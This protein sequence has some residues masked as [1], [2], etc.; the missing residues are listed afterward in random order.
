M[1]RKM[2]IAILAIFILAVTA[3]GIF[4][5]DIIYTTLFSPVSSYERIP[6]D[7]TKANSVTATPIEINQN[8]KY[9]HFRFSLEF[10]LEGVKDKNSPTNPVEKRER[11]AEFVGRSDKG[12]GVTIPVRL[13][14]KRME[15]GGQV[16]YHNKIY[17]TEGCRGWGS[18]S[19]TRQISV[20][21]MLPGHYLVQLENLE[22][23]ANVPVDIKVTLE[24]VQFGTK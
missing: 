24:V 3:G 22:E 1:F 13:T 17:Y 12:G 5:Y 19:F 21:H 15:K 16:T 9:D 23:I 6:I 7:L 20:L 2:L 8:R 11:L 14:I 10:E 4:F 18:Y